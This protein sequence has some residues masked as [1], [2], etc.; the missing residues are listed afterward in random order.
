MYVHNARDF[1]V[2]G[3]FRMSEGILERIIGRFQNGV[4]ENGGTVRIQNVVEFIRGLQ[5]HEYDA[6]IVV[7]GQNGNGKSMLMLALLK[8]LD[9]N[10]IKDNKIVYAYDRTSRLI[11]MLRDFKKSA[12]GIDEGKKFFH[13]KQSMTLESIVLTNMIEY[14]RENRNC[15]VVC[16]NDCR[17]LSNNYRNAKVQM[18]IWLLDRFEEGKTK[19]YGLVFV[20][21]PAIEEEDKFML[22]AFGNLYSFESIRCVAERLPTFY[23]YIFLDDIKNIVSEDEIKAYRQNKAAGIQKVSHE[24]LHKLAAKEQ[25]IQESLE[26][27]ERKPTIIVRKRGDPEQEQQF[28]L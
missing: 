7:Q 26:P 2:S 23:G 9:E 13:Y 8:S 20:G 4:I 10:A 17:R 16:T 25:A 12:V 19:S 1:V 3:V 24:Y 27:K 21:N 5:H 14:A 28:N 18:V 11:Q 6:H 22:N 15:F